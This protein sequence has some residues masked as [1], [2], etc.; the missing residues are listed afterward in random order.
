M[1]T[2]SEALRLSLETVPP[3][4]PIDLPLREAHGRVLAEDVIAPSPIPPW[5]NS[6]MD[7]Y[8]VRSADISPP[9]DWFTPSAAPLT[10]SFNPAASRST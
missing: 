5:D 8:A 6:A 10:A 1:L 7:G 9:E 2:I 4:Q 3:V